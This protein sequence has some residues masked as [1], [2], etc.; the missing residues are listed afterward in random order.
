M[1]K[2]TFIMLALTC[3][4]VALL[5]L[6]GGIAAVVAVVRWLGSMI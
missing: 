5:A 1:E 6:S 3:V 4:G 2:F